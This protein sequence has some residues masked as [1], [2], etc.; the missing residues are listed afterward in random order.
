[1]HVR[2]LGAGHGDDRG[3]VVALRAGRACWKLRVGCIDGGEGGARR[4]DRRPVAISV[5]RDAVNHPIGVGHEDV[6][7]GET[8]FIRVLLAIP[9]RVEVQSALDRGRA[10]VAEIGRDEVGGLG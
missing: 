10:A 6:D 4:N 7:I 1:M 2:D 8:F 9:V 5:S 3:S